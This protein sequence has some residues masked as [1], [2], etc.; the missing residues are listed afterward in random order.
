MKRT[1]GGS[2]REAKCVA[3]VELHLE[4]AGF[5]G[6]W[7]AAVRA[8]CR[9]YRAQRLRAVGF[10]V[11][12][13][14]ELDGIEID[15][16]LGFAGRHRRQRRFGF[17]QIVAQCLQALSLLFIGQLLRRGVE[18]DRQ[19]KEGKHRVWGRAETV[20]IL[21]L[22]EILDCFGEA[23]HAEAKS[24]F[25]VRRIGG[26]P[27]RHVLVAGRQMAALQRLTG[28]QGGVASSGGERREPRDCE[29]KNDRTY[30]L[31]LPILEFIP[32]LA[33]EMGHGKRPTDAATRLPSSWFRWLSQLQLRW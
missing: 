16:D 1:R 11:A 12:A 5:V 21:P 6:R 31:T 23:D 26:E 29:S 17:C 10:A 25:I 30:H 20:A 28:L 27:G 13:K 7:T 4:W 9:Q 32:N 8:H 14:V 15:D 22:S 2:S 33:P 19:A 24:R 3:V 18:R